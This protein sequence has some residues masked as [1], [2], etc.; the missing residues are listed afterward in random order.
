[1]SGGH[2]LDAFNS[3]SSISRRGASSS[4]TSTVRPRNRRLISLADDTDDEFGSSEPQQSSLTPHSALLTGPS[5]SRQGTRAPSPYSSRTASP[6]PSRHPSRATSRISN[7]ERSPARLSTGNGWTTPGGKKPSEV[8]TE[9]LES[10][11]SSLQGLASNLLGSDNT[12]N[13]GKNSVNGQRRRKPSGSGDLLSFG[14]GARGRPGLPSAWGPSTSNTKK[15]QP[16]SREERQALVQAKK[17]EMLLQ[18]DGETFADS[19]GKHKRKDSGDGRNPNFSASDRGEG[20]A[21]VYIHHVQPND[22]LTGVSIRY[23][24]PLAVLRK[25]NGFWP[26]DTIQSRKSVVLPTDSCSLKGRRISPEELEEHYPA[27]NHQ[28][29]DNGSPRRD[30]IDA[31]DFNRGDAHSKFNKYASTPSVA[32]TETSQSAA[33]W[34]HE[35]WVQLDGFSSPVERCRI[36]RSSLGFFPRARRKSHGQLVAYSDFPDSFSL[37]PHNSHL[38]EEQSSRPSLGNEPCLEFSPPHPPTT[39]P[40]DR[41]MSSSKSSPSYR[42]HRSRRSIVLTGPGGIGTLDRTALDPGPAPDKLNSFVNAHMPKLTVPPPP[43]QPSIHSL[44]NDRVSFDSINSAALSN[45]S[46]TGLENVGGAIEGWFRKVTTK[47]QSGLHDLQEQHMLA[48]RLNQFGIGGGGDLIELD[49]ARESSRT[50]AGGRVGGYT[51]NAN[52]YTS[53]NDNDST[54]NLGLPGRKRNNSSSIPQRVTATTTTAPATTRNG[55]RGRSTNGS[56]HGRVK[57]D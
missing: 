56:E 1:M 38:S 18:A 51:N 39:H 23:G 40:R 30:S 27:N 34:E 7:Q 45:T 16:S 36:P 55:H 50:R 26:S 12:S 14:G 24:C 4:A 48:Q 19:R 53:I 31:D 5:P 43:N 11:W 17:R 20:N 54:T 29:P 52:R 44:Q 49:D 32:G 37:S 42:R 33:A 22:S 13:S 46:S 21:L 3:S 9:I 6:I 15:S 25:A 10:S 47:A 35:S 8:A 41:S 57:D 2:L 28:T